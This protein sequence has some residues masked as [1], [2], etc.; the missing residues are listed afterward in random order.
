MKFATIDIEGD[1][2]KRE[3]NQRLFPDGCHYDPGTIPWIVTITITSDNGK[4]GTMSIFHKLPSEGD[5]RTVILPDGEIYGRVSSW[6]NKESKVY[7]SN[8]KLVDC[9]IDL[10]DK[11]MIEFYKEIHKV[12]KWLKDNEYTVAFK[13]YW[14]TQEGKLYE[15]DKMLL[16]DKFK[17]NGLSTDVLDCVRAVNVKM[18]QT[19]KQTY[20]GGIPNEIFMNDGIQHNIEDC[21]QLH[22]VIQGKIDAY[23]AQRAS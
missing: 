23:N 20:V 16:R 4:T 15:Y 9:F 13:G 7:D 5:R 8:K 3:I 22:K 6:H 12:I 1:G 17:L 18:E 19:H 14:N 2:I 10:S 11:P 21:K